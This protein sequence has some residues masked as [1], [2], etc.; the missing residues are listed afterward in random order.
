[1]SHFIIKIVTIALLLGFT[2]SQFSDF[3][4][5]IDGK[6]ILQEQYD[7]CMAL[8]KNGCTNILQ[9]KSCPVKYKC[10][11]TAPVRSPVKKNMQMMSMKRLL[12]QP[13]N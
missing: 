6:C 3:C 5:P 2:L 11:G 9:Q 1:M 4:G 8:K 12:A 13:V 7:A 10:V